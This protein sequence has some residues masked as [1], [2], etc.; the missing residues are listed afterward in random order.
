MK[1]SRLLSIFVILAT[2]LFPGCRNT[3][4]QPDLS[5]SMV[6]Y[7]YTFDE[8]YNIL[9]KHDNVLVTAMGNGHYTT[10]TDMY[11]RFEFKSI[12]AGTYEIDMEKEGFGTMKQFG[13]QHLGGQPTLLGQAYY[14]YNMYAFFLY[15]RITSSI[16]FL[17]YEKDTLTATLDFHGHD[18]S[19]YNVILLVYFSRSEGFV[20]TDAEYSEAIYM[21]KNQ[22]VYKGVI[23]GLEERFGSSDKFVFK[24]HILIGGT[25]GSGVYYSGNY[26]NGITSYFDYY[27]HETV[28]PN[29]GPLSNEYSY[30]IP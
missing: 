16:T 5:G 13:I 14:D 8:Y 17:S 29:L 4:T 28:Y 24:G 23:K 27:L 9:E 19:A 7:V 2:C 6:G 10:K 3:V 22:N 25:E 30:N 20:L 11:G 21:S 18:P 26:I 15:Q 12:P 1:S